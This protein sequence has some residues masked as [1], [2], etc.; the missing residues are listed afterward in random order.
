[1]ASWCSCGCRC[2]TWLLLLLGYVLLIRYCQHACV[3]CWANEWETRCS[4]PELPRNHSGIKVIA[5]GWPKTGTWTAT[6]ALSRLGYNTYHSQEFLAQVWSP[7]ADDYWMRPE[8]GGRRSR[9][10][11]S[12]AMLPTW[13]FALEA[14]PGQKVPWPL[15]DLTV[16]K[17]LNTE[18]LA[19]STS[20]CRMDAITTDGLENVVP[21]LID[22]SPDVKLILLDWRAYAGWSDSLMNQIFWFSFWTSVME[23]FY[24]SI[25]FLPWGLLVK[26]IDPFINNDIEKLL[27]SGAPP[28]IQECPLGVMLWHP[29]VKNRQIYSHMSMGLTPLNIRDVSEEEFHSFYATIRK[30]V[31]PENVMSF[32]FKKQGWEELCDFL[33]VKECPER[34]K[35]QTAPNGY[36]DM[37]RKTGGRGWKFN[38]DEPVV[39][40]PLYLVLHWINWKVYRSIVVTLPTMLLGKLAREKTD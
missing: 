40:L 20:R 10:T 13:P 11:I 2:C 9:T 17:S 12:G 33:Q 15:D 7:L 32:D 4:H 27:L 39:L 14:I 24:G 19:A 31:R 1:M 37:F 8:N 3:W 5:A 34:G 30:K 26:L 16:L 28:F 21:H 35:I 25:H 36:T 23:L 22:A 6:V 38:C 18:D 29:F